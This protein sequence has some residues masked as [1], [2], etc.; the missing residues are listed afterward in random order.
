MYFKTLREPLIEQQ[1]KRDEKRDKL[2]EQLRDNQERIVQTVE[3]DPQKAPT[4]EGKT[5]PELH[6]QDPCRKYAFIDTDD[7][8]DTKDTDEEEEEY[9]SSE[10]EPG[11]SKTAKKTGIINLDRGIND[12]HKKLLE[13]K[14][15]DLPFKIFD[16]QLDVDATMKRV[17][18]KIKRS[19]DY[20]KDHSTKKGE[21]LKKLSKKQKTSYERNEKELPY[22]KDYL[23][24][25]EHIKA[26]PKYIGDGIRRYKQPKGNAY[27]ITNNQYGGLLI[28]VPS[29]MNKMK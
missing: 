4:F 14:G 3:Y 9:E 17:K 15:Y 18:E 23:S 1:E 6:C 24:R 16:K 2:F 20:I 22:F 5:L 25:L 8:E 11:T 27:K 13:D 26:A 28:D 29:L 21:P 10:E 19:E 7:E 12:E